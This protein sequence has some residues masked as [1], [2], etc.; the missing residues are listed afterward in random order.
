MASSLPGLLGYPSFCRTSYFSR[1]G[2]P[3]VFLAAVIALTACG[4][5]G[6]NS[7]G[8]SEDPS[9]LSAAAA[10][11]EKIF[12]DVS[13]SASGNMACATCHSPDSAHTQPND[14]AVPLGG[15]SLNEQ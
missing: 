7:N 11:G 6:S 9:K 15:P 3:V 5:G 1:F 14:V 8:A 10:V 2:R 4:G 13:L 12:K